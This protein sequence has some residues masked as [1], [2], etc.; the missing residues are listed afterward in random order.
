MPL[1]TRK[2]THGDRQSF[3]IPQST[4]PR[5]ESI[6]DLRRTCPLAT[7]LVIDDDAALRRLLAL[8]L[9]S[10]FTAQTAEHGAAGFLAM[11]DLAALI[12]LD[13]PGS[14]DSRDR[15]PPILSLTQ[16]G[17]HVMPVRA[18]LDR[19]KKPGVVA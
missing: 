17:W 1:N 16:E 4:W 5:H 18:Q 19:S 7:I 14:N 9:T 15:R 2:A 13:L 11:K 10:G 6:A 3:R 12:V 8:N